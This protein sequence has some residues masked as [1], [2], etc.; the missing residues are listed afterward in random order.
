M[1]SCLQATV[2]FQVQADE[3]E[4]KTSH[5][6]QF[7]LSGNNGLKDQNLALKWTH[8]NIH[9][10]GGD[11]DRITVHGQSA[12]AVSASYHLL[13]KQSAGKSRGINKKVTILL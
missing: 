6:F 5:I 1:V 11:A 4:K 10:F 2:S 8:E 13:I 3:S 9:L 7:R 12:G